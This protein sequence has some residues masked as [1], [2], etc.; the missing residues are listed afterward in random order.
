VRARNEDAWIIAA[1]DGLAVVAD[2]MGG[3]PGGDTASRLAADAATA[4][5]RAAA[6]GSGDSGGNLHGPLGDAMARCV[7]DAHEAVR[8]A[9]RD[10][11][12]LEGMGTTLTALLV[13]PDSG[14]WAVGHAGD[15]RAYLLRG[16]RLEQITRDDTWVQAEVE[17]GRIRPEEARG[18]P[19]AHVLRQCVGLDEPPEP[20]RYIG[21][22]RP[23]DRFLLCSDGLTDMVEDPVIRELMAEAGDPGEATRSLVDRALEEGGRD[24]VTVVVVHLHEG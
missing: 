18:H 16:G 12:L 3:H 14:R 22:A 9:A 23:D 4:T 6:R 11:P 17:A 19:A 13:A 8:R 5:L 7:L 2:G 1:E 20:R 10:A 15:S 24:N 21:D